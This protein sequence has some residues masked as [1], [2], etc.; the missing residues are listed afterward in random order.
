MKLK[1]LSKEELETM[2]FGEIGELVLSEKGSKMKIVDVFKK[3]CTLLGMSEAEFEN[4]VADFFELIST[5][6]KF[7]VLDKGYC[8][9]RKKHTPK[10]VIEDDE[11]EISE[12]ENT[13]DDAEVLDEEENEDDNIFY[14]S[15]SDEDD[16]E[17][18]DDELTDFIVVDEDETSM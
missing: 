8:D 18:G 7:I 3:V 12:V 11:E 1:D 13:E 2:S 5:D 15:S 10:L 16:V 4:K 9:L 6:K 14:D 17:D